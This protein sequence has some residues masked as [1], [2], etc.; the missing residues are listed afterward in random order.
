MS[1]VVEH[2]IHHLRRWAPTVAIVLGLLFSAMGYHNS[3]VAKIELRMTSTQVADMVRKNIELHNLQPAHPQAQRE[4]RDMENRYAT[5]MER[6]ARM[7]KQQAVI[8]Q[9]ISEVQKDL[10]K[11]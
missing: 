8:L 4:L 7:E 2:P 10:S 11:H 1:E 9:I 3:M 6:L 5:L